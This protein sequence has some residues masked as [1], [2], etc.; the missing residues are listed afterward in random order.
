MVL[1]NNCLF[2]QNGIRDLIR[3]DLAPIDILVKPY[4]V[5][6]NPFVVAL[7]QGDGEVQIAKHE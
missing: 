6:S 4:A 3:G 2:S 1:R 5:R 7:R